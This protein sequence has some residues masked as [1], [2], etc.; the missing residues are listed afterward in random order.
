MTF[1]TIGVKT[2]KLQ[3][4]LN[5]M[6]DASIG[7]IK[8]AVAIGVFKGA[9]LVRNDM[10]TRIMKGP[11]SGEVYHRKSRGKRSKSK[12]VSHQASAPGE[13]PAN[14]TGN[15]ARSINVVAGLEGVTST[16]V[17]EVRTDYASALE[18]GTRHMEPRPFANPALN[19]NKAEISAIIRAEVALAMSGS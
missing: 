16:S 14:D 13:A 8:K 17:V 15:L 12:G 1:L 18:F 3:T 5:K 6:R 9:L 19:E 2:N 4:K 7:N 10:I 11:K